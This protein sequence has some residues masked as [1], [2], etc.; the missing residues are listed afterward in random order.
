MAIPVKL[1]DSIAAVREYFTL[2]G[3]RA[4]VAAMKPSD[5][6]AVSRRVALSA[7]RARAA[8][9]LLDGGHGLEAMRLAVAAAET[10]IEAATA[11]DA[12]TRVEATDATG[13]SDEV[14]ASVDGELVERALV[15]RGIPIDRASIAAEALGESRAL[16]L[17]LPD[18]DDGA[19]RSQA[20]G[21]LCAA[22]DVVCEALAFTADST[23]TL[24]WIG[25]ARVCLW[26]VGLVAVLAG[27][28]A[29]THRKPSLT[30]TASG[31]LHPAFAASMAVDGNDD[32]RFLLP[33]GV[34]G[35]LDV[36]VSPPRRVERVVLLNSI[37]APFNDRST[38]RYRIEV[39][40]GGHKVRT[41]NGTLPFTPSPTRVTRAIERD[42]V[43][44]VRIVILSHHQVGGGLAEVEL[45]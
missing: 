23:R 39:Y 19:D 27:A 40:S 31:E 24:V 5:A 15:R 10:A 16:A 42:A 6:S 45:E 9:T 37:N 21:R 35:Y 20:L 43:E 33:D 32:T 14:R 11:Y 13:D 29:V 30:A 38:E 25:R 26:G 18:L 12:T 28:Y 3:L 4:E 8:R 2:A 41:V 44:R 36:R 22:V 1:G 34:S 7:Q 17:D